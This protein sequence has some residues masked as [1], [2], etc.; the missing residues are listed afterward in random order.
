MATKGE[1][2]RLALSTAGPANLTGLS[3][4]REEQALWIKK[5]Q[6]WHSSTAAGLWHGFKWCSPKPGRETG[7]MKLAEDGWQNPALFQ[8]LA[9]VRCQH[10]RLY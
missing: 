10:E 9:V 1:V 6:T 4:K 3:S 7:W 2:G 5:L 8:S